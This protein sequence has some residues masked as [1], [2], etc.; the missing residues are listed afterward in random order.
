MIRIIK[1]VT[2]SSDYIFVIVDVVAILHLLFIFFVSTNI[3]SCKISSTNF[4]FFLFN[5]QYAR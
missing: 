1:L 3:F 5:F 2:I 4:K